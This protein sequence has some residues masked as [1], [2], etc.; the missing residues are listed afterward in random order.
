LDESTAKRLCISLN[1]GG[2]TAKA[3]KPDML[4]V[5]IASFANLATRPKRWIKLWL[6]KCLVFWGKTCSVLYPIGVIY[7][8]QPIKIWTEEIRFW[9]SSRSYCTVP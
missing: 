1:Q 6:K 5:T 8:F 9:A 4:Q 3:V 7:G 2:S